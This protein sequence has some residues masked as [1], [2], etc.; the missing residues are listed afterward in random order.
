MTKSASTFQVRWAIP[1]DEPPMVELLRTRH[2]EEGFG[3][4]DLDSVA[5][6]IRR[7][8]YRDWAGIGII[9]GKDGIEGSVGL[10]VSRTWDAQEEYLEGLWIFVYE[11]YR[12]SDRL[13]ALVKFSKWAAEQLQRPLMLVNATRDPTPFARRDT[14]Q[15]RTLL[16]SGGKASSRFVTG[17]LHDIWRG[18]PGAAKDI[19]CHRELP[20]SGSVFFFDPPLAAETMKV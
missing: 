16:V 15:L 18:S 3:T 8:L 14:E 2:S 11:D 1:A 7:G 10:Y 9:R 5:N 13:Q 20:R 4:F 19:A 17:S 6:V 12:V